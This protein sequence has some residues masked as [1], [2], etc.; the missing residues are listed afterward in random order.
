MKS[1]LLLI[2]LFAYIVSEN[3]RSSED[4]FHGCIIPEGEK[5][6]CW[7]NRNGCC[8]PVPPGT[9][10]TQALKTCCKTKYYDEETKSYKYKYN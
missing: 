8:A 7:R 1:F 4:E 10:C 6:C 5:K 3:L 2:F 9:M